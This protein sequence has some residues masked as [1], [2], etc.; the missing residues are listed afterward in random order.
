MSM[1][2]ALVYDRVNKFGG[3]ERVLLDLHQIFPDAPLFT[4]VY[5]RL[6]SPWSKGIKVVPTFFNQVKFLRSRH[7]ILAPLAG[8]AFETFDLS[9][10]DIVISV[11]SAEAKAVITK[12]ETLHL[13]YCLTP[14]RYLWSGA[15]EYKK[16]VRPRFLFDWYL[17]N[18][19][20][21]DLVYA[22]RPD[23][24]FSIS[25]EV[26]RRVKDYYQR[27]SEVIYPGINYDFFSK[28]HRH[29]KGNYYLVVSR[30]VPYKNTDLVIEAFNQLGLPLIVVGTGSEEEKLK[31]LAKDN[32]DFVGFV[33][34][35]KLRRLYAG[36]KAL[37]YPQRED[38][39][40][41]P[42]EAA[43]AGT[44][45]LGLAAGGTAETVIDKY[46]G[47]FFAEENSSAIVRAVKLFESG[48]HQISPRRCREQ[49]FRF[50]RNQ[51]R[52]EFSDKVEAVWQEY[53]KK[54]LS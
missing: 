19:R 33:D 53:R 34:D 6:A 18:A 37:V 45:T 49:A 14:T 46:T 9:I 7:E 42:L 17:K 26:A 50:S 22:S 4:L 24:Y 43:A 51:F 21:S 11:T 41:A 8:L 29:K 15:E 36:A 20:R 2:V 10:F 12:P 52:K 48:R 40:L 28:T 35:L 39:G 47:L 38:F 54:F 30:L 27:P 3:A 1:K 31:K 16:Q 23:Y 5:D 25:H 32:I 13:C 44:P